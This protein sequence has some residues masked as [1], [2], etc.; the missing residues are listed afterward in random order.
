MSIFTTL[1]KNGAKEVIDSASGLI[2]GLTTTDS[3][4]ATAK[5][6]LSEI[7]FSALDKLQTMQKEVILAEASGNW[8]QRSWRPIVMLA[9]SAIVILGAF[10]EIPYLSD[11][12]E[13][14]ALLKIGMG[15]YVIGRSA[16]KIGENVTKNI[17]LS[18][19]KK[20]DRKEKFE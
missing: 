1:F 11:D 5:E 16:E 12:S 15:G 14:W 20:K 3:E 18:A 2:D 7:V 19:L 9:F 17:D 13:F 8:L 10:I 6:K 4:K